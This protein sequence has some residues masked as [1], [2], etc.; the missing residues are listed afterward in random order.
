[1]EAYKNILE[2][3]QFE[4]TFISAEELPGSTNTQF[5]LKFDS[6]RSYILQRINKER[7]PRILPVVENV[8]RVME[9]LNLLLPEKRRL[10]NSTGGKYSKFYVDEEGN[11]WRAFDC[12]ENVTSLDKLEQNEK[13]AYLLGSMLGYFQKGLSEFEAE[14]LHTP[15]EPNYILRKSE[16]LR[17]AIADCSF[18]L[19]NAA[20]EA[21]EVAE[22][23][24]RDAG[25]LDYLLKTG[26]IPQRVILYNIRLDNALIDA[27]THK[28]RVMTG[29]DNITK[30]SLLWDFSEGALLA[31]V[32]E[33]EWSFSLSFY[34]SYV[35]GFMEK[36]E[37]APSELALM[38]TAVQLHIYAHGTDELIQ[39]LQ[40]GDRKLLERANGWFSVLKQV[41][42]FDSKLRNIGSKWYLN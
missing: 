36:M 18:D 39:Y 26:E 29:L 1:M 16:R 34:D 37:V 42:R 30:G 10:I 33:T 25:M 38:P 22:S 20:K 21:A 14:T 11:Y 6:G 8:G 3:F 28:P 12:I 7:H 17:K 23:G 27:E 13:R 4:G 19:D 5:M 41:K 35:R 9:Y 15:T 40:T 32:D 2:K 31:A 24:G